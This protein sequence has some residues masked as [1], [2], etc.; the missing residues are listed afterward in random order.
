MWSNRSLTNTFS[1]AVAHFVSAENPL[2]LSVADFNQ[3]NAV[4]V[5][6]ALVA[7][8]RAVE[9][10][11]QLSSQTPKTFIYTGNFLNKEVIP[12]LMSN[13]IGKSGAAHIMAVASRAYGPKG[14]K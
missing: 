11:Q 14:Y 12:A 3:D 9:G 1:A 4:N 13:G 7:A 6:G 5:A 2:E 10:F 8:R